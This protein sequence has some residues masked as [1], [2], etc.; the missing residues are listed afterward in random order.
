M[1]ANP[2]NSGLLI[3]AYQFVARLLSVDGAN[4]LATVMLLPFLGIYPTMVASGALTSYTA[5]IGLGMVVFGGAATLG[6]VMSEL[7]TSRVIGLKLIG[8][9]AVPLL[10]L[11]V[12]SAVLASVVQS[13]LSTQLF[14]IVVAV[15]LFIIAFD[16]VSDPTPRWVPSMKFIGVALCGFILLDLITTI[17]RGGVQMTIIID[18]A[19]SLIQNGG[20]RSGSSW[21]SQPTVTVNVSQIGQSLTA[22]ASGLALATAAVILRPLFIRYI[23]LDRFRV[24]CAIALCLVGLELAGVVAE[25]PTLTVIGCSLW[26]AID[27]D[28]FGGGQG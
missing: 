23:D 20:S 4:K 26:L 6:I 18:I 9:I 16:I 5:A 17:V 2:D 22:A 1:S 15:V 11:A 3:T 10:V 13:V 14:S 8:I 28:D 24:G 7:E 21:L 12:V 25:A 27:G 19:T